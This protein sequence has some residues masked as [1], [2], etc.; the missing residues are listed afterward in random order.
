MKNITLISILLLLLA[1]MV[2]AQDSTRAKLEIKDQKVQQEQNKAQEGSGS[3]FV[4]LDGDGYNDNAPDHDGDGI[5]NALD[6]DYTALKKE[7][8]FVDLDG[9][10]INDNL[11]QQNQRREQMRLGPNEQVRSGN[12]SPQEGRGEKKRQKQAGKK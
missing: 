5:P 7:K 9:D 12:T 6:P 11:L 10:G 3:K 1:S 2:H 4:D 8:E